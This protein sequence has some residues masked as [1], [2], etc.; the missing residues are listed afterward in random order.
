MSD[1]ECQRL[2]K[3]LDKIM[4]TKKPYTDLGLKSGDLAR[5]AGVSGHELSF[6]FNQYLK[7]SYYDYIN[8]YRVAE[9]KHIV[10]E[11]D[12]SR[13]TLTALSQMCGFSSR[14][15]FFRHFKNVT[16]VTPAEYLRGKGR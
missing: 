10:D 12:P 2:L 4:K 6:L 3:H 5:L 15:T 14:A 16:G 1:E 8:W 7:K 9:F 11:S 13:Y